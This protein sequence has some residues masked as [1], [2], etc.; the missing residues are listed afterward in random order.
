MAVNE[1]RPTLFFDRDGTL[2]R[3]TGYIKSPEELVLFPGVVEAIKQCN[4]LGMPVMVVTNQSGLARGF[5]T[6]EDLESIHQHLKDQLCNGG[7]WIDDIFV[8]PHHPDDGCECRKPNPGMIE[9]AAARYSIDLEKSY[10]VG[11]K[12]IDVELAARSGLKG[13]LVKTGPSS[14]EAHCMIQAN[15]LSVVF[16]ADGLKDAVDWILQDIQS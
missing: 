5:F 11:D 15:Q 13:V 8:C 9:Q 4:D 16:I 2:N 10:V 6:T 3:D 1:K 14:E 12:Y 7:A